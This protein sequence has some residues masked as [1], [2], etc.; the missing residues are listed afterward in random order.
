M[1]AIEISDKLHEAAPDYRC[2]QIECE[3]SNS[4][5]PEGLTTQIQTLCSELHSRLQMSDINKRTAISSTRKAYKSLGKDPNRYRPSAEALCRRAV[6][7]RGIYRINTLVDLINLVSLR[8]GYSIGGFDIDKI[9]GD[10]LILGVG[11]EG[12][13]FEAIG[14]GPLNIAGLPVFRDKSGGIGTP[15][16][17]HERTKLSLE[18]T[19]LLLT[20][21][22]YG[23]ETPVEETVEMIKNLL[24][25]YSD[26]G[27]FEYRIVS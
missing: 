12:E 15:T 23:L 5:T 6:K 2:I 17:D 3:V 1:L 20:V 13:P 9:D 4:S 16:S 21:N 18:T 24:T 10:K 22:V 11:E 25:Q 14:R 26:L 27:H 8:T 19:K 7:E